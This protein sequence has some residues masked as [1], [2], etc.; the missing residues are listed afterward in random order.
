MSQVPFP[1]VKSVARAAPPAPLRPT[2]AGEAD[3][4]Y[5][6]DER[7]RAGRPRPALQ[8]ANGVLTAHGGAWQL[9][10]RR[11]HARPTGSP[12]TPRTPGPSASKHSPN[13]KSLG[14]CRDRCLVTSASGGSKRERA[15]ARRT[16]RKRVG[17]ANAARASGVH[18]DMSSERGSF[19]CREK[20]AE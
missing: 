11:I 17:G 3:R 7:P 5:C 16:G 15:L 20:I 19:L 18:V 10:Q 1:A 9:Q 13:I 14:G 2:I 8:H 12:S 4:R 6:S